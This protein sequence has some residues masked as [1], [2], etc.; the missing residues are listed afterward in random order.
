MDNNLTHE[1]TQEILLFQ[2]EQK[3][4]THIANQV[5][6]HFHST[7]H[8]ESHAIAEFIRRS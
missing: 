3:L 6:L 7:W 2:I 5:E 1:Q 4:R 8:D